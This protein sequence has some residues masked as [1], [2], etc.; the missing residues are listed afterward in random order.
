MSEYECLP[1]LPNNV[2]PRYYLNH[3]KFLLKINRY[4]GHFP[5]TFDKDLNKFKVTIF[6]FVF[7]F[8]VLRN[9]SFCVANIV[10]L[11]FGR[12]KNAEEYFGLFSEDNTIDQIV[13]QCFIWVPPVYLTFLTIFIF[14]FSSRL[15]ALSTSIQEFSDLHSSPCTCCGKYVLAFDFLAPLCAIIGA[16]IYIVVSFNEPAVTMFLWIRLVLLN[17]SFINITF[18]SVFYEILLYFTA[19]IIIKKLCKVTSITGNIKIKLSNVILD[20][21]NKF[22]SCFGLVLLVNLTLI[23]IYWVLFWYII[24]ETINKGAFTFSVMTAA[25][26]ILAA[27]IRIVSIAFVCQS[28]SDSVKDFSLSLLD[29]RKICNKEQK[30]EVDI[31]REKLKDVNTVTAAGFYDVNKSLVT[32]VFA[33]TIQYLVVLVTLRRYFLLFKQ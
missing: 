4:F 7:I 6:S 25:N 16:G 1:L 28:L 32:T 30:E 15:T 33:Y 5:V 21:L 29:F 12:D 2:E 31:L 11:F 17:L 27:V 26:F 24:I 20:I 14:K 8:T 10:L 13:Y 18:C 19:D 22:N 9:F 3:L 23:K